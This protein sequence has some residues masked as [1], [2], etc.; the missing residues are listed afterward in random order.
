MSFL[1]FDKMKRTPKSKKKQDSKAVVQLKKYFTIRNFLLA[2]IVLIVPFVFVGFKR[3][4][5]VAFFTALNAGLAIFKKRFMISTY[6]SRIPML[7]H[8]SQSVEV[9]TLSA[10]ICGYYFGAG[11]GMVAGTLGIAATYIFEKRVSRWTGITIP[12]YMAIGFISSRLTG[13]DIVRLGIIMTIA[14]N[15]VINS[16]LGL[17]FGARI[18][19]MLSFSVVNVLFNIY[20]FKLLAPFIS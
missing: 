9:T 1:L 20:L 15:V 10:V 17:V 7:K 12:L 4:Y 2:S 11:P 6:L 16:I 13:M 14:Y 19:N 5:A 8:V 3:I 18:K